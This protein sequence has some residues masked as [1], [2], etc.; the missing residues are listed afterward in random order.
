M[1][2][3]VLGDTSSGWQDGR[4][5]RKRLKPTTEQEIYPARNPSGPGGQE[6][7]KGPANPSSSFEDISFNSAM[8]DVD[9]DFQLSGFWQDFSDVH[10]STSWPTLQLL[11]PELADSALWDNANYKQ[12]AHQL[13]TANTLTSLQAQVIVS[14]RQ[15]GFPRLAILAKLK[16]LMRLLHN[17]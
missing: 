15:D 13:T 5:R 12:N 4:G 14:L 2:H 7:Q 10:E 1:K 6:P 3:E 9:P 17:S 8:I 16:W 11:M